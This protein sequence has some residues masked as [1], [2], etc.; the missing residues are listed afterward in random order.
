MQT[1][2]LNGIIFCIVVCMR[3]R[4]VPQAHCLALLATKAK[5]NTIFHPTLWRAVL[6]VKKIVKPMDLR[7]FWG[8]EMKRIEI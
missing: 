4:Y 2:G 1:L 8:R 6:A 5:P 3:R 7:Y